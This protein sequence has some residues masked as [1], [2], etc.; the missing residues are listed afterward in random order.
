MALAVNT[1]P[2]QHLR[3]YCES[4]L[5]LSLLEE[6]GRPTFCAMVKISFYNFSLMSRSELS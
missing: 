1:V 4:L 6:Y 3:P 5:H 2:L